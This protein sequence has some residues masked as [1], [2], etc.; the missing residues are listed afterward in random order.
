MARSSSSGEDN[1]FA[2]S[3]ATIALDSV[4]ICAGIWVGAPLRA[5]TERPG[6]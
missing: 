5:I 3:F 6:V 4:V 1:V 2:S